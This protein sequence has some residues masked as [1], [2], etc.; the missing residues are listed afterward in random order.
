M[1]FFVFAVWVDGQKNPYRLLT[2]MFKLSSKGKKTKIHIEKTKSYILSGFGN[3]IS[4][5]LEQ[6]TWKISSVS[7]DQVND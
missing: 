1:I 2:V 7:R 5:S 4:P 3:G 6:C